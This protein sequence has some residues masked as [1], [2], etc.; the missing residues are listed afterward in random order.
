MRSEP[1]VEGY[2][3]QTCRTAKLIFGMGKNVTA[4]LVIAEV[5][6]FVTA[7]IIA[8]L[9]VLDPTNGKYEPSFTLASLL[10][11]LVDLMRR[12]Y[13]GLSA[14][15]LQKAGRPDLLAATIL[16]S[17]DSTPLS[18]LLAQTLGF[19]GGNTNSA[20]E[21]WLRLELYGYTPAG[22]MTETDVV[23]EYREVG[24]R[25]RDARGRTVSFVSQLSFVNRHRFRFGVRQLEELAAESDSITIRDIDAVDL[26]RAHLGHDVTGFEIEPLEIAAVLERIRN[27]FRERLSEHLAVE[28]AKAVGL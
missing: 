15:T 22:G 10:G 27:I 9:W 8:V 2:G 21:H 1:G 11:V 3:S 24:G 17:I 4:L 26:I 13:P 19:V 5:G 23:P 20:F 7:A 16:Q 6:S 14:S 28:K 18:I 25:H 12:F